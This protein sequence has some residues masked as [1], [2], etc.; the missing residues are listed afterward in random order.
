MER[1]IEISFRCHK[2]NKQIFKYYGGTTNLLM[3]CERCGRYLD[4]KKY[5]QDTIVSNAKDGI[6]KI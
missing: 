1:L 2:C 4:L 6:F 5:T 3:K